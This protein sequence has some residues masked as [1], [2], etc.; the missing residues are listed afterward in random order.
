MDKQKLRQYEF[1]MLKEHGP[2]KGLAG[3]G[4]DAELDLLKRIE[5]QGKNSVADLGM[6]AFTYLFRRLGPPKGSCERKYIV[7]YVIPTSDPDV[8][9]GINLG[10]EINIEIIAEKTVRK[11]YLTWF[12]ASIN[13]WYERCNQWAI[14]THNNAIY[15]QTF[16]L[17]PAEKQEFFAP[18]LENDL[19][20]WESE[21]PQERVE[22]FKKSRGK[23]K[24]VGF[25]KQDKDDFFAWKGLI[26]NRLRDEYKEIEPFPIPSGS[27]QDIYNWHV[28]LHT[29]TEN[30]SAERVFNAVNEILDE[31]MQPVMID[32]VACNLLGS[33]NLEL[34]EE[35]VVIAQ[36]RD[37]VHS[38]NG[39]IEYDLSDYANWVDMCLLAR[40][41]GKGNVQLGFQ[42]IFALQKNADNNRPKKK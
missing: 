17:L 11:D 32:S 39:F 6:H 34:S 26:N 12:F 1:G 21:L 22:A 29:C 38:C 16:G 19:K 40:E 36:E 37:W 20:I 7:R 42:K 35:K 3:K 15:D 28:S 2:L 30:K 25:T 18:F 5:A 9:I 24:S 8:I 33:V 23:G 31:L 41:K 4:Y 14:A 10:S 13:E 27:F